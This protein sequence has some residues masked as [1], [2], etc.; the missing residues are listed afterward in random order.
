M[1]I[2]SYCDIPLFP[3]EEIERKERKQERDETRKI[4]IEN[5]M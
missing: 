5:K 2:Y 3:Q 1:Q 4:A